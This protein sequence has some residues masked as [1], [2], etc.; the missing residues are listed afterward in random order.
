M[1]I[2]D[3]IDKMIGEGTWATPNTSTQKKQLRVLLSKPLPANTA[4]DKIYN[5]VGDDDLFDFIE[6]LKREN[7]NQD[8]RGVVTDW[9]K[10]NNIKY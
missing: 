3:K 8:V 10:R 5:L 1:D 7:G 4:A 2:V 9:L 6:E